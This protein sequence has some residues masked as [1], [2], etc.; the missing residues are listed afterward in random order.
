VVW[1]NNG[2]GVVWLSPRGVAVNPGLITHDGVCFIRAALS[3]FEACF[4]TS[5]PAS[6]NPITMHDDVCFIRTALSQFEACFDT[7][8]P[9]SIVVTRFLEDEHKAFQMVEQAAK[10]DALLVYTL[11]RYFKWWSRQPSRTLCWCIPWCGYRGR[12]WVCVGLCA[13]MCVVCVCCVCV[14]VC[15]WY[16]CVCT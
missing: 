15:I 16:M 12:D 6:I 3:Q 9:A 13:G 4:D 10:Q 7:S 8:A 2:C 14:L 11:V 1:C 5:A